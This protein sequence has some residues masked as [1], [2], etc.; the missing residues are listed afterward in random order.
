MTKPSHAINRLYKF[1]G[2]RKTSFVRAVLAE[3]KT[4]DN[5]YERYNYIVLAAN[6]LLYSIEWKDTREGH[7]YW[8]KI[9]D[10]LNEK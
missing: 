9:Y 1:L 6:V 7:D 2:K 4:L 5:F 3:H 10:K 8:K